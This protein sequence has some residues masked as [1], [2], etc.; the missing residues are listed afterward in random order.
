MAFT[1]YTNLDFDQIKLSIKNYLRANGKFTDFDFE[2]SNLSVLIDILAY[3]TY[4]NSYN[5]N[6][7]ANESFLET[8]T[9]RENV[10]SLARN[11]GYVPRSRRSARA[12]IDFSVNLGVDTNAVSLTLKAGLVAT[13]SSRN[14]SVTFCIPQDITVPVNDGIAFFDNV[15]IYEGTYVT[16]N[17]IVNLDQKD[18]KFILPNPFVDTSTLKVKVYLNEQTSSYREYFQVSN[19]F[20]TTSSS[21]IYYLYE[22]SD[23]KYELVFGDGRF[24]KKLLNQNKI[25]C[26]YIVSGGSKGNG[27]QQFSFTGVLRDNEGSP[28]TSVIPSITTISKAENGD[29][30]ESVESIKKFAPKVYASQYRA[31]TT[32]DYEAILSEIFPNTESVTAFGGEDLDPPQYG[33]VFI[34]VKPR[35]G[36]YL[37]NFVKKELKEKLKLYSVAGVS[38]E[39]I[40]LK[41]LFVEV[42]ST[43]YYNQTVGSDT[44]VIEDKVVRSLQ[45]YANNSDINK[46]GGRIKY[47][48]VVGL[49]DSADKAITSNITKLLMYRQLQVA[50]QLEADYELCFGNAFHVYKDSYNIRSTGFK[51]AGVTE[52]LYFADKRTNETQGTLF[53]FKLRDNVPV[54]VNSNVGTVDY[55]IG[56]ILI[57]TIQITSTT[58]S[59]GII[60]IEAVPESYDIIGLKELY[61]RMVL[62]RDYIDI[63]P[64]LIDSGSS[65][66]GVRHISTSSYIDST[67]TQYIRK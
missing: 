39:I 28:V 15:E 66:S 6:M 55:K 51:I 21:E 14:S 40:D 58:K 16:T 33:K 30:I 67:E 41:F 54:I 23:E 18:Q 57:N 20:S 26:T 45:K 48:K 61:L 7:V 8:S 59:G 65:S 25:E 46:F 2:G 56:E 27:I 44:T 53:I 11:I 5:A 24:G 17:F 42:L 1:Q 22:I 31:V 10:V 29:F 9:L 37:S 13:G 62:R 34:T 49:I 64:D 4:I 36:F 35:N 60:E 43:V 47:S 12:T 32:Q 50:L 63:V 3:N 19:I 38:P 52:T